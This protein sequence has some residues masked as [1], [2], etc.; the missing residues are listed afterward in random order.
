MSAAG[1]GKQRLRSAVIG[2]IALSIGASAVAVWYSVSSRLTPPLKRASQAYEAS[3][4]DQ[5]AAFARQSLKNLPND[6]LSL[7]L[8]ARSSARAGRHDVALAIYDRRLDQTLLDAEDFLLLG[9]IFAL[10][11]QHEAAARSW[12]KVLQAVPAEP[13][14]LNELVRVHLQADRKDEAAQVSELLS[15]QPGWEARVLLMLAGIQAS[16]NDVPGSAQSFRRALDLEP[17]AID[18]TREPIKLRKLVAR[19]FLRVSRSAEA[20][21]TVACDSNSRT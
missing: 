9:R 6:P 4:W 13:R 17:S 14:M 1:H 2:I 7:R 20:R 15:R 5:A 21:R 3:N 12:G 18:R 19:T 8:L 16:L 10:R 11:G